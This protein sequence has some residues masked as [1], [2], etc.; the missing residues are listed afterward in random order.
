M[1]ALNP[2]HQ[3][4]LVAIVITSLFAIGRMFIASLE[5]MQMRWIQVF[6]AQ[7][8]RTDERQAETNECLRELSSSQQAMA[9]TLAALN[10][11]SR[12]HGEA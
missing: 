2:A 5:R 11:R 6:E 3:I 8:Q 7:S 1:E 4:G 12:R 9:A 10:D